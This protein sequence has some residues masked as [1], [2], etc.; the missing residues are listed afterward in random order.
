MEE[1]MMIALAVQISI[2][3]SGFLRFN[4]KKKK[5]TPIK[6]ETTFVVL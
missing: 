1:K 3:L 5:K 2:R 6:R 4:F